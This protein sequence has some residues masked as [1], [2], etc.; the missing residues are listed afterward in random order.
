ME[1]GNEKYKSCIFSVNLLVNQNFIKY[2]VTN[3]VAFI[4]LTSTH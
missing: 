2:L 1:I 3:Q 4:L